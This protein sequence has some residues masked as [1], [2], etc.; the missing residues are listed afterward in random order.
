M[1]E[2][3]ANAFVELGVQCGDECNVLQGDYVAHGVFVVFK[4]ELERDSVSEAELCRF[5]FVGALVTNH[6]G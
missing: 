5:G 4:N 1:V 3:G 6:E 2:R